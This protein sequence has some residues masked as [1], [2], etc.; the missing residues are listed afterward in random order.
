MRGRVRIGHL[1]SAFLQI[2]AKIQDRTADK[3]R[4]FWINHNANI[5]ALDENVAVDWTVDQV[6]L[7]LQSGA[8]ASDHGQP[9]RAGGFALLFEQGRQFACTLFSVTLMKRSLPIL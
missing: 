3:K 1:K 7:V 9:Q 4:A 6:H 8:T 2:I 5:A